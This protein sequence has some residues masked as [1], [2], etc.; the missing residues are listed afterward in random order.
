M[1]LK[2]KRIFYIEDD[3]MN[4]AVV[5]TMLELNGAQFAFDSWGNERIF[6]KLRH[7]MPIDLILLDLMLPHNVSGYNVYDAVCAEPDLSH[8][9]IVMVSAA[10]PSIEMPRARRRGF[11]GY[12][13]KP[14]DVQIFANQIAAFFENGSIWAAD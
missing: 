5:K 6:N 10:D 1:L 8:I 9:P 4:R 12:I 7:F 3:L 14:I 2:N 11:A 13:S